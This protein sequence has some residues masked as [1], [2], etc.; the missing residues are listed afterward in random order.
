MDNII[1]GKLIVNEFGNGF[2]NI[3]QN[4]IIYISKKDLNGA[5]NG[6]MV[7]VQF[8]TD[9]NMYYGKVINYTLVN[10]IFIGKV[11][12]FYK[13]NIYIYCS[14]LTNTNMISINTTTHLEKNDW[15]KIR[16][17]SDFNSLLTGEL[18]EKLPNDID[19]II[20][21]KFKLNEFEYNI[22]DNNI[23]D[24]EI[25][26]DLNINY[27]DQTNLNT[28]TIDPLNS[29]DCD[30]AFS[31]IK[32]DNDYHIYVHISDVSYYIN[33]TKPIFEKVMER[34]NTYYG[35]NKNWTMIPRYYADNI[36]SILPNKKTRVVTNHFIYNDI[37]KKLKYVNHFY[38][39]I[40]SKN[41][42][43][44]DYIDN[45]LE[46]T[47]NHN[48]IDTNYT[49]Y[50]NIL[51][52]TSLLLK[53]D[54]N[55]IDISND[56]NAHSMIKYWMI[57]VNKIM[58]KE[59][60]KIYRY[61]PIPNKNKFILFDNLDRNEIIEYIKIH[62]DKL[63]KYI[64]KTLL[65][66]AFYSEY[67]E[68]ETHY[69]LGLNNYTHW[70]SPIRR[71]CDLLNH[72]LLRGYNIELNKYLENMNNT[73]LIQDNIEKFILDFNIYENITV[74]S[75]YTGIIIGLNQYCITIYIEDFDNKFPIH[76]SKL[77]NNKL[78]YDKNNNKLNTNTGE[79]LYKLFDEINVRVIKINNK[80]I[81][82][83]LLQI[84]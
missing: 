58:C 47:D 41:K 49:D 37:D 55:D 22:T 59:I 80:S 5:F 81:E 72:C 71:S 66:K 76:I 11:D 44:Y 67:I 33:P 69:G 50:I 7:D 77:S 15:V 23:T 45:I 4:F 21:N 61:N 24:N 8:Y 2:V 83:E 63:T 38:S 79:T 1:N 35:K 62:Q 64:V 65:T 3:N 78:Y 46:N 26:L 52:K 51:Y 84:D 73:E 13:N 16:I 57:E 10:K 19:M 42:Y 32:I 54:I 56:S 12:H 31:I 6:E 82:F 40:I 20:E 14:E 53:T 70:T 68:N 36:C 60:A 39:I 48:N 30:D 27:I 28:F 43:D 74:N 29:M 9:N 17:I 25:D 18:L 75:N 34:G